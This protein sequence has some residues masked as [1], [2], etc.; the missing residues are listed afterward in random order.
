MSYLD[1][2]T[3]T[4][5]AILTKKGRE[6][7]AQGNFNITKFA[8]SDDEI[9]YGLY[10]TTHP[11]GSD[12]YATAIENL[13]L[14]EAIPD[15]TKVM[16]Y[17][18]ITLPKGTAQIPL[19][20]TGISSVNLR[21]AYNSLPGQTVVISPSTVNGLNNTLGY[22]AV[23]E[24]NFYCTLAVKEPIPGATPHI[25]SQIIPNDRSLPTS[26]TVVGKS[27]TLTAKTLPPSLWTT[28][29]Q[30]TLTIHGNET[31]GSI[32]MTVNIYRDAK[33]ANEY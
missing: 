8:L 11:S 23:L 7:F 25:H 15:E 18:L 12:Y 6:R 13:P 20:S 19:I 17:K 32:V 5:N 3:I 10:N 29:Y 1:N 2:N 31:G 16:K 22:T 30:T 4:V 9:D 27:F 21:M 33:T 14:L 28:G 24:E 26:T